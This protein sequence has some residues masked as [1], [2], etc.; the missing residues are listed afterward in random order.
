MSPKVSII[1]TTHGTAPYLKQAIGSV[2]AQT[3]EDWELIIACDGPLQVVGQPYGWGISDSRMIQPV[4]EVP[5]GTRC[6]FASTINQAFRQSRGEF[7]TYLCHD[8]LYLPWRLERMVHEL[9]L[10]GGFGERWIVFGFQQLL[11]QTEKQW[12]VHM[13]GVTVRKGNPDQPAGT[14]DHSSVMHRRECFTAAG[15]WDENAPPRYGDA[16]FWGRLQN[17]G[18]RFHCI[19][20]VLDAHRFNPH[21]ISWKED[22]PDG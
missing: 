5:E 14:V 16:Y 10:G 9:E 7:I 12:R 15:G 21:S 22:Y 6:R 4:F 19:P 8:D 18:Y 17:A 1:L 2:L 13:N 20:E 11:D 3:F